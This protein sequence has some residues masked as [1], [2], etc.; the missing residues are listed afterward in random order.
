MSIK[1][2]LAFLLVS[3]QVLMAPGQSAYIASA[4]VLRT[5][6]KLST[7]VGGAG[8]KAGGGITS[9]GHRLKT[10]PLG[11]TLNP[12]SL[13]PSLIRSQ[14]PKVQNQLLLPAPLSVPGVSP[15]PTLT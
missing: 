10:N 15:E 2:S 6:G 4:M 3:V 7:P 8:G 1:R 12:L 11:L 9:T 13:D 14:I 5:P